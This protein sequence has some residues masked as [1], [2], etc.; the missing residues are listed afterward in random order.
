MTKK[1]LSKLLFVDD[2]NDIL[3]IAKCCLESLN[4]TTVKYLSSGE[5][6]IQEALIFQPD[7]IIMDVMMPKMDGIATLKALQMI[8]SLANTP[9]AF[10]TAK[11]QKE[12]ISQ[13]FNLGVIDVIIKPFNPLTLASSIQNIWDKYQEKM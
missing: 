8:P 5:A 10:I 6:A 7:L 12:E 13:Y 4:D 1:S 11:V 9:V 2:D 3:S